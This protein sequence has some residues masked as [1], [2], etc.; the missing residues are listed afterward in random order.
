MS[1]SKAALL[2][3]LAFASGAHQGVVARQ[4]DRRQLRF[5]ARERRRAPPG[6]AVM[7]PPS[8]TTSAGTCCQMSGDLAALTEDPQV[9]QREAYGQAPLRVAGRQ[10]VVDACH[11]HEAVAAGAHLDVAVDL[12]QGV[13][14]HGQL[15]ALHGQG[16]D[17]PGSQAAV[18]AWPSGRLRPVVALAYGCPVFNR[19]AEF[20]AFT[21]RRQVH[22][23]ILTASSL[24]AQDNLSRTWHS[25]R[26][27]LF[28]I[29]L[30]Q[31]FARPRCLAPPRRAG[32][33]RVWSTR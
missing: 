7:C 32:R 22:G 21:R 26:E 6:Q 14:Q 23:L 31:G 13:G 2:Q 16:L 4:V 33:P 30:S 17:H 28:R 9:V 29:P 24:A 3:S 18:V 8:R 20:S 10:R 5:A 12:R 11:A 1:T 25:L 19:R 15:G 27:I